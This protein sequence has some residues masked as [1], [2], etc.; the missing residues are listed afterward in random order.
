MYAMRNVVDSYPLSPLQEGMLFNALYAPHSGVD[1]TQIICRMHHTFET[2]A[3]RRA[4]NRVV[5]RHT[6]LRTAFRWEGLQEPVQDVYEAVDLEFDVQDIRGLSP[7]EQN[8]RLEAHLAADRHRGFDISKPPLIRVA[9]LLASEHETIL[10]WPLHHLLLDAFSC[11]MILK[12][13]FAFYEASIEG[14]DVDLDSPR[15]YRAYIDWLQ[16]QDM[17]AAE[18]F[19]RE[20]L[21]GYTNPVSLSVAHDP[22][23]LPKGAGKYGKRDIVLPQGLRPALKAYAKENGFTL[24]TC[25]QAAWAIILSRYSGSPDVVWA[26]VRGCRGVPIEGADSIIGMFIN[27][28]PVRARMDERQSLVSFLK[29]LRE[30][31]ISTRAF[32]HSPLARIQRWSEV[33]PAMPLFESLMNYESLPWNALLDSFGG[34]FLKRQWDVRHQTNIPIGLDV[35][36]QPELRIVVD[37]DAGLFDGAA[38]DTMLVHFRTLLEGFAANPH[39]AVGEFPMLTGPERTM[40]VVDWNRTEADYPRGKTIHALFEEQVARTPEGTAVALGERRLTYRELNERAN[41]LARYLGK[42]GVGPGTPVAVYMDRTVEMVVALAGTLKAGGA[43][44]P[45]DPSYPRERLEFMLEDTHA[46]VLLTEEKFLATL[47]GHGA[48]AIRLDADWET[49][50]GERGDNPESGVGADDCAYI[51]YTSGSTGK[52]KG[53]CCK[54]KSVL[55]LFADFA[56]RVPIAPG[57]RCSL[58]TSVSFDVSVY[59]IFSAL[60]AGGALHIASDA[61]RFDSGTYFEW[62]SENCISSAYVP[63]LM[64]D[65]LLTWIE[66]NPGRLGLKRLLVGVEPIDEK[67]LAA[68]MARVPGLAIING[69]GPTET[70]ICSTL[71]DVHPETARDRIT[72]IGRPVQNSR[73]YILDPFLRPVPPGVRGEIYIGGEG[74]ARGYLNRPELTAERFVPDPF[75][76]ASDRRLYKTGDTA[77]YLAD[78]TIE[79]IG[80]VDYQVKVRGF[81]VEP[82]EVEAVLGQHP[83]VK[84]S[85]VIAKSDRTGTKRLI[86]YVVANEKKI[87]L[88]S[89]LRSFLKDTLPDYMVPAG[90]VIMESFP[91]TPNGKLDRDALPEPEISRADLQGTYVAPR[92]EIEIHLSQIWEKVMGVNPI[93]V[94]D[95]FFDLGGHSLLAVRLFA[96]ITKAFGTNIPLAAIFQSPTIGEIASMIR[97]EGLARSGESLIAIQPKGTKPPVFF[98][99]AYGGGVFFYRELSDNLGTDQPFYGLQAVGLD[100]KRP[101]HSRV[102]DMAAYYIEEM[103]KVQPEG[104]YYIG[105]RCLGAYVALEM[106]NLLHARGDVVGLLCILDSYWVPRESERGRMRI[107]GHLKNISERGFKEK[108]EYI[109]EYSGYRLIKTKFWLAKLVSLLIFKLGR[110]I[111]SFMRDFYVNVYIPEV[112]LRAERA[113]SPAIYPG[114]I[115]FFQATAEID[116]DP[117]MFWGRLTSEGLDVRMVPATHKDILVDPNVRT[118]AEKLASALEKVRTKV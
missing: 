84:D 33:P 17:A 53:V 8:E 80:R 67:L 78:G 100:G 94:N 38:M 77:R 74:L 71:F 111:P 114:I 91:L 47:P 101:P 27:T 9:V 56:R 66:K 75:S 109:K 40:I 31:H 44:V 52:P 41:K 26:A 88:V 4:W 68:I 85:V 58:W 83:S 98:V 5:A 87:S 43:Y 95:S 36:E 116:R 60:T 21:K 54:H 10:V 117:R 104:P 64:L 37:Y 25:F 108:F 61:I 15:P 1:I 7:A 106:A 11:A 102:Q 96:E 115:T 63:P 2:T 16:R 70:T 65:D 92:D 90:F 103:R 32:E 118:L 3:F 6:I 105:G 12:E 69:Y 113:Y 46:P 24:Y 49:V 50:A 29:G 22:R 14:K 42:R 107:L 79:F 35:Y 76:E 89:D 48:H 97:G 23:N 34:D 51:I 57:D 86:A 13:V 45:M 59:E 73:I 72:P 81:R 93:G 82:G 62:L 55:N 18:R 99:H 28:L 20:F 112:N 110:P 19:W 39:R 30:Q